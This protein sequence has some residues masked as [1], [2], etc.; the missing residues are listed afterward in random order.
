MRSNGEL[1]PSLFSHIETSGC[2]VQRE[3]MA[4]NAELLP[5]IKRFLVKQDKQA[6]HGTVSGS[7][8]DLRCVMVGNAMK[9]SLA[10]Y[11]TAEQANPSHAEVFQ[12]QYVVN[13]ADKLE[14]KREIMKVFGDGKITLPENYRSGKLWEVLGDEFQNR[15][16]TK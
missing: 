8:A 14:L 16:L 1:K 6:W 5:W 7:C 10:V 9:R 13:E 15:R 11:D 12:S 2:S 3:A 4:T